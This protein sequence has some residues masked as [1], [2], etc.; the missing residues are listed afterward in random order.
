MLSRV[1]AG[2]PTGHTRL[3]R[4]PGGLS[5]LIGK[6]QEDSGDA[7]L[8]TK[9]GI[10]TRF[11]RFLATVALRVWITL[12]KRYPHPS[13]RFTDVDSDGC[14]WDGYESDF[15]NAPNFRDRSR[16]EKSMSAAAVAAIIG[17]QAYLAPPEKQVQLDMPSADDMHTSNNMPDDGAD[18]PSAKERSSF[19]GQGCADHSLAQLVSAEISANVVTRHRECKDCSRHCMELYEARLE[20]VSALRCCQSYSAR[21]NTGYDLQLSRRLRDVLFSAIGA[22]RAMGDNSR[23]HAWT[24]NHDYATPA[25]G[26]STAATSVPAN[27]TSAAANTSSDTGCL[28]GDRPPA[29][30][31]QTATSTAAPTPPASSQTATPPVDATTSAPSQG[32][33]TFKAT[34]TPAPSEHPAMPKT[35][36]TRI[37][38]LWELVDMDDYDIVM[39]F[40]VSHNK[41][42]AGY[43]YLPDEPAASEEYDQEAPAYQN[44]GR[45][46]VEE[47]DPEAPTYG[48]AQVPAEDQ[49]DMVAPAH[50]HAQ[51]DTDNGDYSDAESE[52]LT[53][54]TV[55][56]PSDGKDEQ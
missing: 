43:I 17:I 9:G 26:K 51:N 45:A 49:F 33:V 36:T 30:R 4:V 2:P 44:S 15:D 12:H 35:S 29:G 19:N 11:E 46:D 13:W 27:D 24:H 6:I 16:F 1:S 37:D 54:D 40:Q 56:N 41:N 22:F 55:I 38:W 8:N 3:D 42:E 34:T 25:T 10:R 28:P 50:I 47:Y 31:T 7:P 32:A 21:R 18:A 53:V 23:C 39:Y 14:L 20:M 52:A 48:D 5:P